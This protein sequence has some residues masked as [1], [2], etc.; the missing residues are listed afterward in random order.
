M[1]D[2]VKSFFSTISGL[3][4]FLHDRNVA[5][6]AKAQDTIVAQNKELED[7]KD[8]QNIRNGDL[9]DD[10]SLPPDQRGHNHD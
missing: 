2:L 9:P 1:W 6:G 3:F 5:Q 7:I 10:L 4:S 8:A